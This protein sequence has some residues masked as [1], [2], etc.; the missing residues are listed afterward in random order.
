MQIGGMHRHPTAALFRL[1][2]G[3]SR[4]CSLGAPGSWWRSRRQPSGCGQR[5]RRRRGPSSSTCRAWRTHCLHLGEARPGSTCC[6][7]AAKSKPR[8]RSTTA[9]KQLRG[10]THRRRQPTAPPASSRSCTGEVERMK[11][12]ESG[13]RHHPY[14]HTWRGRPRTSP[15]LLILC[16]MHP[17]PTQ[18][19]ATV[20]TLAHTSCASSP[21]TQSSGGR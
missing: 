21:L 18:R 5:V 1:D 15:A 10:A 13:P 4:C 11:V 19:N 7:V 20:L 2:I 9:H 12:H 14:T 16:I 3:R 6:G 17:S 8:L